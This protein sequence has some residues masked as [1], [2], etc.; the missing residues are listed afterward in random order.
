MLKSDGFGTHQASR[1]LAV[2]LPC[3]EELWDGQSAAPRSIRTESRTASASILRPYEQV[4]GNAHNPSHRSTSN[5]LRR[6][7]LPFMS[8]SMVEAV[9]PAIIP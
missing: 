6:W 9:S 4:G 3:S 1:K 7:R 8:R 2:R 5:P